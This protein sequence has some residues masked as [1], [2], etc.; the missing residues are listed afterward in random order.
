M[1]G[2]R[3]SHLT[4]R[5]VD[6]K[7]LKWKAAELCDFNGE[8]PWW[9][10]EKTIRWHSMCYPIFNEIKEMFYRKGKRH[11]E[12]ECISQLDAIGWSIWFADAAKFVKGRIVLN[13]HIHGTANT[14]RILKYFQVCDYNAEIFKERNWL[15]IRFD[16]ESSKRIKMMID[17]F[18]PIF[19]LEE[20]YGHNVK[21]PS[22]NS[23][24]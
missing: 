5:G 12:L 4:M 9:E 1:S 8:N 2:K 24:T 17:P 19:K 11:I 22:G 15:R 20:L 6:V 13:T 10:K 16:V 3:N 23:Q 14:K 21:A 7:W 18:L